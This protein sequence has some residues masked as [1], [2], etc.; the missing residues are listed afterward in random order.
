[1]GLEKIVSV[2]PAST[3]RPG[4]FSAARKKAQFWDTRWACCMLWVTM[5]TVTSSAI[6]RIVS[7]IR[8]VE[9][10][11]SAEQGSSMSSTD[12]LTARARAMHRRC[13]WPPESSPPRDF[14]RLRTSFHSPALVSISSTRRSASRTRIRE[15]R[16]PD[17]TLS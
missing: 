2:G 8:R 16:R 12:G 14:R 6:S 13:C 17:S 5:T 3:S 15:N 4:S 9:V 1:M 7:S 10:G 11:S